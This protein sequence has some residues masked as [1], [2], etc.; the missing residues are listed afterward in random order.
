MTA[1]LTSSSIREDV[2]Q[3]LKHYYQH[4]TFLFTS[5]SPSKLYSFK[6]RKWAFGKMVHKEQLA[7]LI[8][9]IAYFW[10]FRSC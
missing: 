7:Q 9:E 3:A 1:I 10:F 4:P 5:I 2:L 6:D 8:P